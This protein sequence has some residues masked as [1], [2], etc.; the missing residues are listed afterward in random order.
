[1][2]LPYTAFPGSCV[3]FVTE[4]CDIASPHAGILPMHYVREAETREDRGQRER[5][6]APP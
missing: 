4:F 6:V 5:Y 1:M 2:G 3:T